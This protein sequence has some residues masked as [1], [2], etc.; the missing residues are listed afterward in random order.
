MTPGDTKQ[1]HAN[2]FNMCHGT[3][4]LEKAEVIVRALVVYFGRVTVLT[5]TAQSR[6]LLSSAHLAFPA[7]TSTFIKLP[8]SE[9]HRLCI[10]C[11]KGKLGFGARVQVSNFSPKFS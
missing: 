7:L 9:Q 5:C 2:N 6:E 8:S 3:S 1:K 4:V 10:D 11:A